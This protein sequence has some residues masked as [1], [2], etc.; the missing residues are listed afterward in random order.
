MD[1]FLDDKILANKTVDRFS[2]N[3]ALQKTV[4]NPDSEFELFSDR[5]QRQWSQYFYD[6]LG[7]IRPHAHA[8]MVSFDK[9]KNL[10][11]KQATPENMSLAEAYLS[12]KFPKFLD[13]T[14]SLNGNRVAFASFPRSGNS[15]LRKTLE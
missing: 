15:F 11:L 9:F 8:E 6:D 5:H 12:T 3:P 4:K 1:L 14:K 13:S 2:V 7:V 10:L